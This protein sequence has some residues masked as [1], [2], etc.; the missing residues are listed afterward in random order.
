MSF[1]EIYNEFLEIGKQL[2]D[3]IVDTRIRI[4]RSD[5]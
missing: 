4:K 1:D 3:R 2:Q 5:S